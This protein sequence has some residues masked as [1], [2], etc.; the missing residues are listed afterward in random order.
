M[1]EQRHQLPRRPE[2]GDP[3]PATRRSADTLD[4]LALRRSTPAA[5][6]GEPGPGEEDLNDLLRL[7][8]RVPDHRKLGPWRALTITGDARR[9]LGEVFAEARGLAIW[10]PVKRN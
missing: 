2:P 10:A 6:L 7:A 1:T 4:L 8:F 5:A 3:L 9:A